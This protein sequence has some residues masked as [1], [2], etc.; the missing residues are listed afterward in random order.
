VV[1]VRNGFS[2]ATVVT[3][4]STETNSI[5]IALSFAD[6]EVQNYFAK[7]LQYP[8]DVSEQHLR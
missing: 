4:A 2:F 5:A 3:L 1:V 7:T 8:A 6:L